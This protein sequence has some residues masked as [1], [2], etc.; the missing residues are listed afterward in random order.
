M[1]IIVSL[2]LLQAKNKKAIKNKPIRKLP[3]KHNVSKRPWTRT[4]CLDCWYYT[5]RLVNNLFTLSKVFGFHGLKELQFMRTFG[6]FSY[7]VLIKSEK[8]IVVLHY[9]LNGRI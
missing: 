6:P 7:I 8:I 4:L 3:T 2:S 5:S 9:C 1:D